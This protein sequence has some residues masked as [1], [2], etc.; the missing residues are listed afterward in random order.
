M[1]REGYMKSKDEELAALRRQLAEAQARISTLE[2]DNARLRA[3][4]TE[5]ACVDVDEPNIM[6]CAEDARDIARETLAPAPADPRREAM[7]RV[8]YLATPYS[9]P[10]PK[11]MERRFSR[12]CE[13]SAVLMRAGHLVFS[14][15][16][17]THPIAVS[18]ELPRG[19]EFWQRYDTAMICNAGLVLVVQMPG[20]E[21]SKGIAG[22]VALA[23]EFGVPVKYMPDDA[24]ALSALDK[25]TP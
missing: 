25:V 15:I 14:P 2:A 7:E 18:G 3:G 11:V 4:V 20:W 9:D 17:H 23:Q 8:I 21:K 22:E 13:L 12:A 24:D 5:I 10:D 6:H 1:I 16:A 19:W